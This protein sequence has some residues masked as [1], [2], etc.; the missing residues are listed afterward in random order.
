LLHKLPDAS[1]FIPPDEPG[2]IEF[3]QPDISAREDP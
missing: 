2:A 3:Q 1:R